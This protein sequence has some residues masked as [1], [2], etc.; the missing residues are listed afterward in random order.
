MLSHNNKYWLP[1]L[2]FLLYSSTFLA[3]NEN[4]KSQI[5]AYILR[6]RSRNAALKQNTLKIENLNI[7]N[8]SEK[9]SISFLSH[10][11]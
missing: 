8:H 6:F 3:Q 7:N 5:S 2:A 11:R 9:I 1:L 4:I 10:L